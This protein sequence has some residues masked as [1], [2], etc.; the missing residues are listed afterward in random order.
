MIGITAITRA[1]GKQVYQI[2]FSYRG[3]QC[4]ETLA[5]THSKAHEAFCGRRRTEVILAIER[6]TFDY[7]EFF[8]DSPRAAV[9]G[10]RV[11][12]STTIKSLLEA[13]RDRTE[14]TLE[15]STWNSYRRA[16]DNILIPWCGDMMVSA[17]GPSDLRAWTSLQSV[18]LKRIRNILLPL[19]AIFNEAVEDG[20]IASNPMAAVQIAK[21][22]AI[23]KRV[24]DYEPQPYS[25]AELRVLLAALPEPV[26]WAFQLWA[27]TGMRTGELIGLRWPRVDLEAKTIKVTE[28]TTEGAD[29]P[30]AKTRAGIRT[31]PLLPAALEA[32]QNLRAWTQTGGDRVAANV[33]GRLEDQRWGANQ[34]ALEWAKAHKGTGI[35]KRNPYQLRHTFASQLLSQGEN[36]AHIARL[37][38]HKTIEMVTRSYG[39][40]VSEGEQLGFDRPPRRYGMEP[41]WV[42]GNSHLPEPRV[43]SM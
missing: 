35:A 37:L 12:K 3:V 24:S 18:G 9:F 10:Q 16:I 19:R 28:T 23:E 8:P 31:I 32:I 1:G 15:L 26:R 4:R 36:P 33:N 43:N 22:V 11:N 17:F 40:W 29:K 13:Y 14:K 5:L 27:F 30:R 6:G 42:D 39:R 34:L 25:V 41:L 20:I 38:G 7:G 21:L 2:A